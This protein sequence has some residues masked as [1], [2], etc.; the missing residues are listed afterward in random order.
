[1]L[2][3]YESLYH[4]FRL[5]ADHWKGKH[6]GRAYFG[7]SSKF[8]KGKTL[9]ASGKSI[10]DVVNQLKISVDLFNLQENREHGHLHQEYLGSIGKVFNGYV[11]ETPRKLPEWH[12]YSCHSKFNEFQGLRCAGCGAE[13]CPHCGTC[14]CG[15][16]GIYK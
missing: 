2:E 12:C 9:S 11:G 6:Q 10:E 1:M 16:L 7:L 15:Y 5:V 14:H 8:D 13:V 4:G 3:R